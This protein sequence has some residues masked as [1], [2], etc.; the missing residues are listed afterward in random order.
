MSERPSTLSRLDPNAALGLLAG[1]AMCGYG[2]YR[3]Y[4]NKGNS[5]T[6]AMIFCAGLTFFPVPIIGILGG[7][8][9]LGVAGWIISRGPV[10]M[11]WLFVALCVIFG[12]MA[13]TERWK[14]LKR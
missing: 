7:V 4:I 8:G 10:Q 13:I 11:D 9:L 1:L 5:P 2:A 3:L 6:G 12:L 14:R